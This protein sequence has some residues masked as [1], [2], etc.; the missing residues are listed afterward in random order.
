MKLASPVFLALF[1]AF[2]LSSAC[3]H[4]PRGDGL[5]VNSS[6]GVPPA[7]LDTG[8][9][10][11]G[12]DDGDGSSTMSTVL[13]VAVDETPSN[14]C[15]SVTQMAEVEERPGDLIMIADPEADQ[16]LLHNAVVNL[17]PQLDSEGVTDARVILIAGDPP[18]AGSDPRVLPK[19]DCGEW[20]CRG[21]TEFPFFRHIHADIGPDTV[22]ADLLALS[23]EWEPFM[24]TTTWKHLWI[25]SSRGDDTEIPAEEFA[26]TFSAF[27]ES[28]E[29]FTFNAVITPPSG[30]AGQVASGAFESLATTTS[31]AYAVSGTDG[32]VYSQFVESVS[33]R[34][35]GAPLS[36]VYEIPEPPAG[37]TLAADKVNVEY[38]DG[39]TNRTIGFV[40]DAAD[41]DTTGTGWYYDDP[42]APT[43]IHVCPFNCDVFNELQTASIDIVFG[44]DTIPAG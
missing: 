33:E 10:T 8:S 1:G 7:E 39:T 41:C 17:L 14:E 6:S 21:A 4:G 26:A 35:K 32:D 19:F 5:A 30:D 2:A 3:N 34:L 27:G 16:I 37:Q 43:S 25:S 15:V 24:R 13:D 28:F 20:L 9:D 12:A 29:R 23:D 44:C 31:G 36:C 18:P 11:S 42:D 22:L 40:E 38:D